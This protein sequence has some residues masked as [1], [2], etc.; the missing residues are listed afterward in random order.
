MAVRGANVAADSFEVV[1]SRFL[2]G[3]HVQDWRT[4]DTGK[5]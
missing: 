3:I 4:A 5:G 1:R 2:D